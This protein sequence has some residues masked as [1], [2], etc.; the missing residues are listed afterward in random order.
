MSYYVNETGLKI[1]NS[2]E[3]IMFTSWKDL[4]K[5]WRVS[6]TKPIM[7]IYWKDIFEQKMLNSKNELREGQHLT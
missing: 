1:R 5:D 3:A 2:K 6:P 4:F 7:F